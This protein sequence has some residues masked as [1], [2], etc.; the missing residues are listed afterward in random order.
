[1][2]ATR[3]EEWK[4]ENSHD[5]LHLEHERKHTGGYRNSWQGCDARSVYLA[6]PAARRSSPRCT[7]RKTPSSPFQKGDIDKG[8]TVQSTDGT[9]TIQVTRGEVAFTRAVPHYRCVTGSGGDTAPLLSSCAINWSP[10]PANVLAL[11]CPCTAAALLMAQLL[12]SGAVSPP[13]PVTLRA[14]LVLNRL[15]SCAFYA[16]YARVDTITRCWRQAAPASPN[17]GW[18]AH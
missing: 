2:R 1:M 12:R 13:V 3:A 18:E 7:V 5:P 9:C 17:R 4:R 11:T 15:V 8:E 6:A 10:S 14:P 16:C